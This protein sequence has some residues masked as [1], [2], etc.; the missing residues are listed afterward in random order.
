MRDYK[1]LLESE[2]SKVHVL[3]NYTEQMDK[4]LKKFQN[5]YASNTL[6]SNL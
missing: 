2:R 3:Q 4:E 5:R 1:Q 6:E